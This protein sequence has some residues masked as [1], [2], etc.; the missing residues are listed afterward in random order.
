M[1]VDSQRFYG[2]L[3][4]ESGITKERITGYRSF[5]MQEQKR[6]ISS[7][8]LFSAIQEVLDEKRQAVFTVT[9]MSMWPFLCHGRDRVVVESCAGNEVRKGDAV[10]LKTPCGNYLLH[11]VTGISDSCFVTTGDGNCFRDGSFDFSCICAR[12][13][14][15]IRKGKIIDC[16]QRRWRFLFRLWM[17]LFPVRGILLKTL[18]LCSR[19]K[20]GLKKQK[21]S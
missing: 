9:G 12:V 14:R 4:R 6:F 5:A 8:D 19:I 18:V 10:L 7:E 20:N 17:L 2:I 3:E 13:T 16:S 15:M 21:T 1:T 11:R